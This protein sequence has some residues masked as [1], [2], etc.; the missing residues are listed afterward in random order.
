M[1]GVVTLKPKI[2]ITKM[3][4]IDENER[5]ESDITDA[6]M[7]TDSMK[8]WNKLG[9]SF[10]H[11]TEEGEKNVPF[12]SESTLID[13]QSTIKEEKFGSFKNI[14]SNLIGIHSKQNVKEE[15]RKVLEK[16]LDESRDKSPSFM[17]KISKLST[18][19]GQ[20]NPFLGENVNAI[21]I[22]PSTEFKP[23]T[24]NTL[25]ESKFILKSKK[26][27]ESKYTV[28]QSRAH[29]SSKFY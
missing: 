1:K 17:A 7:M 13:G 26:L 11:T 6:Y 19:L 10:L 23:F 20:M 12:Q 21:K 9:K 3:A 5:V 4:S 24:D 29:L 28:I 18:K 25:S 22:S 27:F 2:P 16:K 15:R 8:R 14:I